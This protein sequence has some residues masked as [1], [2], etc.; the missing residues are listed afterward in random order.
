ML[1]TLGPILCSVITN[2]GRPPSL[3]KSKCKS[4]L[5]DLAKGRHSF[6][7]EKLL[8]VYN[9]DVIENFTQY[10]SSA[11]FHDFLFEQ[12]LIL[13]QTSQ[14][15]EDKSLLIVATWA[16]ALE[17]GSKTE[18]ESWVQNPTI[19]VNKK[20]PA[21][22]KVSNSA[23]KK[24][25]KI[26]NKAALNISPPLSPP[27]KMQSTSPSPPPLPQNIST[28][29]GQIIYMSFILFFTKSFLRIFPLC[30]V[31]WIFIIVLNYMF[32]WLFWGWGA[33]AIKA[34]VLFTTYGV[35]SNH[36]NTINEQIGN[37][38]SLIQKNEKDK[39]LFYGL[40]LT[41]SISS[42]FDFFWSWFVL[43]LIYS[44]AEGVTRAY[45]NS[46]FSRKIMFLT[47]ICLIVILLSS[48]F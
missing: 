42:K 43:A 45:P 48:S 15:N 46:Q 21:P 36:L 26:P 27:N 31:G 7:I 22:A 44:I 41:C 35:F 25:S 1:E 24:K 6:E 47:S 29:D 40:I 16:L 11:N 39:F 8:L 13:Q 33:M 5:L 19:D 38:L 32:G 20:S 37:P 30:M 17:L 4:L 18:I 14:V 9:S 2:F 3:N 23:K 28:S 10:K 34:F 12:T